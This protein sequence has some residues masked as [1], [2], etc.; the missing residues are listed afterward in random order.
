[1]CRTSELL[2]GLGLLPDFEGVVVHCPQP[3]GR[4]EK[5]WELGKLGMGWPGREAGGLYDSRPGRNCERNATLMPGRAESSNRIQRATLR[6]G[7]RP[8]V[9]GWTSMQLSASAAVS[10]MVVVPGKKSAGEPSIEI[11]TSPCLLL[12]WPTRPTRPG[13]VRMLEGA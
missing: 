10:R 9:H 3:N 5:R 8:D 11:L 4:S 12:A 6:L 2:R 1:M 13:K 7:T